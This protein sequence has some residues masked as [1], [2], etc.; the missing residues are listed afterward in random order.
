M[1]LQARSSARIDSDECNAR[2]LFFLCKPCHQQYDGID[3]TVAAHIIDDL[4]A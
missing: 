4:V 2:K 1:R 3:E